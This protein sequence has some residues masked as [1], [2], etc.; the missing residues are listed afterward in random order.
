MHTRLTTSLGS[1]M[2]GQH[3]LSHGARF[4]R[5]FYAL[6]AGIDHTRGERESAAYRSQDGSVGIGYDLS[7]AW[8]TSLQGRYGHF[9]VEDPGTLQAP[10][11]NSYANVG[12]GGFSLNLDNA[13][14]HTWGYTRFY[15]SRGRHVITDGFRSVDSTTGTRILQSFSLTPAAH[16]GGRLGRRVLWRARHQRQLAAGLRRASNQDRRRLL[17]GAVERRRAASVERGTALREQQHLR[18]HRGSG[19][20]GK[21]QVEKRLHARRGRGTRIPESDHPRAVL[22]PGSQSVAQARKTL[23]LPGDCAG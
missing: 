8:K 22:V 4:D 14:S 13:Y 23:E 3:R 20:R 2:T 15:A 17:T 1:F 12:R 19:I 18:Q 21:L 6:N 5:G 11:A 16:P 10:L 9:H 7:S